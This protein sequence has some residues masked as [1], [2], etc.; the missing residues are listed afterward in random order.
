MIVFPDNFL[1]KNFKRIYTTHIFIYVNLYDYIP[2]YIIICV[3][4]IKVI[5]VC[6][7]GILKVYIEYININLHF[8]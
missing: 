1:M 8:A 2:M 4:T 7:P 3:T 5:I 6:I